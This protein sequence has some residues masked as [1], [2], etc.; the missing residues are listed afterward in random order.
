MTTEPPRPPADTASIGI[1]GPGRLGSALA[2]ALVAP[3]SAPVTV[4][5]RSPAAAEALALRI[6]GVHAATP[7]EVIERCDL[8]FLAVPDGAVAGLAASLSWRAGQSAVH[9]SG[10]L[11]LDALRDATEAGA[12]AGCLHPLQS[13]PSGEPPAEAA[14]RFA[15][16]TCG[17]EAP[18]PLDVTLEALATRLGVASVLRLER[19][20]RAL[21]HAAAVLSS[22]H[23]VALSVAATQAW[24]LAGLDATAARPALAPLLRAAAE[25]TA[26]FPPAEALTGPLARGDHETIERHLH[27]LD[28][29]PELRELY[30][31][32]SRELLALD[33]GHAPEA[34]ERLRAILDEPSAQKRL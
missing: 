22:N 26:S 33:L 5:G 4:A 3:G 27:A 14:R 24:A 32:L 2:A 8:V 10:A 15:G 18:A 6:A 12:L 13:F 23:V 17:L 7:A 20:D 29:V 31:R 34:A 16:I 30:R 11:G 21:Y 25:A 28:A 9:L 1:V 19:V